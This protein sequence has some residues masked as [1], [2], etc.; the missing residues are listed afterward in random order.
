MNEI[1]IHK[2]TPHNNISSMKSNANNSADNSPQKSG[3]SFADILEMV[4]PLQHLP[5][6]SHIYRA[7]GGGDIPAIAKIIGGGLFGGIIGAA[8]SAAVS[9]VESATNEPL[10][11]S[12]LAITENETIDSDEIAR[13]NL[14]PD[15]GLAANLLVSDAKVVEGVLNNNSQISPEKIAIELRRL[16]ESAVGLPA[17]SIEQQ[18]SNQLIEEAVNLT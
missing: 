10:L 16:R 1:N 6:I 14:I 17:F 3:G 12:I 18:L 13:S 9:L 5:V 2:L 8:S 4:N 7:Q 15:D 11:D